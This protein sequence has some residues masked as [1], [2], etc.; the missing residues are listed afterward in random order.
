MQACA[1]L[2]LPPSTMMAFACLIQN[3]Q[4]LKFQ[5]GP[6]AGNPKADVAKYVFD[7][8]RKDGFM[9]GAYF[10]KPDWHSEYYWWPKYATADRNNN[11]DIAKYPWRW[12]KFKNYT[13]NQISE[14]MHNYGSVDILVAGRRL[15]SSA[16]KP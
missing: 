5:N 12:N 14:L 4:I 1:M 3:K 15:G 2:Y 16:V 10:S 6:F 8:F 13:Y 9:I 7:A 11:Y